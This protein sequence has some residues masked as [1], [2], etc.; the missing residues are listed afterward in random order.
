MVATPLSLSQPHRPHKLGAS[1]REKVETEIGYREGDLRDSMIDCENTSES[2]YDPRPHSR[3]THTSR[4]HRENKDGGAMTGERTIQVVA[5]GGAADGLG[6]ASPV[7]E[8]SKPLLASIVSCEMAYVCNLALAIAASK[9]R[10]IA[11]A[12]NSPPVIRG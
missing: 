6:L 12:I 11:C 3:Q 4:A 9:L 2:R 7:P 5:R 8:A 1:D 10:C